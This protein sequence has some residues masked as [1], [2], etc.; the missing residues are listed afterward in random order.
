[1]IDGI[2]YEITVLNDQLVSQSF[3]VI[4]NPCAS[5]QVCEGRR[6]YPLNKR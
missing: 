4:T 3:Y 2:H 6:R 1:M 5:T